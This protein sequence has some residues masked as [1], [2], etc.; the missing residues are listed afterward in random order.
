MC[1]GSRSGLRI[2]RRTI[3][4]SVQRGEA[5]SWEQPIRSWGVARLCLVFQPRL[6]L[7]Q[8]DRPVADAVLLLLVH[9]GEGLAFVF[10]N[11]IPALHVARQYRTSPQ[12]YDIELTYRSSSALAQAQSCPTNHQHRCLRGREFDEIGLP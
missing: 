2:G 1:S 11:G 9:L 6:Q 8:R 12:A 7:P 5:S 4:E 10:E 3:L